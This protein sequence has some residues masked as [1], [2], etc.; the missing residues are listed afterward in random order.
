MR[1]SRA[2]TGVEFRRNGSHIR[3]IKERTQGAGFGFP[4]FM[5][6]PK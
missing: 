1:G 6:S 4:G 2:D 5:D 3:G